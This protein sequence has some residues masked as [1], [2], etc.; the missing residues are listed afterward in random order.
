MRDRKAYAMMKRLSEVQRARRTGAEAALAE[1]RR[2]EHDARREEQAAGVRSSA[3]QAEWAAR[4][5]EE[6]AAWVSTALW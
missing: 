2:G 4:P 1:A 5:I 6:T 3:A